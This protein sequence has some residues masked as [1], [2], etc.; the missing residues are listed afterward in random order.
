[1]TRKDGL[2]WD[3]K[4]VTSKIRKGKRFVQKI[5]NIV[6]VCCHTWTKIQDMSQ[7][8]LLKSTNTDDNIL[9]KRLVLVRVAFLCNF[10]NPVRMQIVASLSQNRNGHV[11]KTICLAHYAAIWWEKAK[12]WKILLHLDEMVRGETKARTVNVVEKR[13][14]H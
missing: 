7:R 9:D 5:G 3:Y 11:L 10:R 13:E 6:Q 12:K 4:T 8:W 14:L 1:M 2:K